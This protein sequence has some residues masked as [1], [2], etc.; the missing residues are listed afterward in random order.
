MMRQGVVAMVVFVALFLAVASAGALY[1]SQLDPSALDDAPQIVSRVVIAGAVT[2]ML[3]DQATATLPQLGGMGR[4]WWTALGISS[5]AIL[6]G[7]AVVYGTVRWT[8]R[9]GLV[10]HRTLIVG[11]GVVANDLATYLRD[12]PEYGLRPTAFYEPDPIDLVRELPVI[13]EGSLPEAI[14]ATGSATVVIAFAASPESQ[15]V[16]QLHDSSKVRAEIFFVPRLFEV[17]SVGGRDHERIRALPV[18]RMRRAAH[19]SPLWRAKLGLDRMIAA[20]ALALL[21]PLLIALA[22][23]VALSSGRPVFFRQVRVGIDGREF[24]IIKFRTLPNADKDESD[25]S[26]AAETTRQP[27]RVGSWMRATSVDELPQLF[28]ILKGEMSFVGPRPERPHFAG[29]FETRY[30]HYRYR[31][32]VPAGLTGL[33]QIN[34]LRGD[35]SISERTRFDNLYVETWS[36]WGDLKIVVR[37]LRLLWSRGQVSE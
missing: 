33:A 34:G 30:R 1:R 21:S 20:L 6:I 13:K 31:H 26:W 35:T 10:A 36:L 28:N 7:R 9:L 14:E 18:Q 25:T 19:R 23:A 2:Y 22:G 37:T 27:G 29:Q 8:R 12:H 11:A 4:Q 24:G 15:L 17:A 32:R 3:S 5:A 16:Q